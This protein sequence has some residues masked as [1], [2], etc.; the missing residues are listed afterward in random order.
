MALD[1]E[2]G[3][4]VQI[5]THLVKVWTEIPYHLF[6]TENILLLLKGYLSY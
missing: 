5:N 1:R 6:L 2:N 4:N 3:G